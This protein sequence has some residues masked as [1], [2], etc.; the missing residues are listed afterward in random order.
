M[1]QRSVQ[2]K[3]L[4]VLSSSELLRS[5]EWVSVSVLGPQLLLRN[6]HLPRAL[7]GSRRR[8]VVKPDHTSQKTCMQL[9]APKDLSS[10]T[11]GL[12]PMLGLGRFLPPQASKGRNLFKKHI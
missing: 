12:H 6:L 2:F 1:S 8:T 7:S 4:K 11:F 10:E 5:R 3:E 9:Y